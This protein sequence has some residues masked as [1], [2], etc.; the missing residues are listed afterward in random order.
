MRILIADCYTRKAFDV[1]NILRREYGKDR[2]ITACDQ[3]NRLKDIALFGRGSVCLG[4]DS[5]AIFAADLL[6]IAQS[7]QRE[8]IVFLPIEEQV[9]L[10]FYDFMK[11]HGNMNFVSMLPEMSAFLL[12]RDKLELSRFCR[13]NEIPCPRL[14]EPEDICRLVEL[15]HPLIVKPRHGSGSEGFL[16]VD[17]VEGLSSLD[18]V[19]LNEY[20]V[21]ERLA[22]GRDVKGTFFLC[23]NGQVLA[24][25]THQ[26]IRT[27]P[28]DGGVTVCSHFDVDTKAIVIGA[29]V[30]EELNWSGL[31]MVE[32]LW[33]G[34]DSR[35][36]VIEINP[37]LWG[38]ILLDQF[39]G[40]FLLKNYIE[41]SLG[42]EPIAQDIQPNAN[43]RWL[44]PFEL[45][46]LVLAKGNIPGFW[47]FGRQT[48]LINITYSSFMRALMFH[49][50]YY[51]R[52]DNYKKFLSKWL[53]S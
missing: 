43:I 11:I 10:L 18:D 49:L 34:R 46:N 15:S 6:S 23:K 47:K 25:Y 16:F 31:A 53:R 27:Y 32:L 8:E 22:N 20:V 36:K 5:S 21:Q 51:I 30:L 3:P 35:Y 39:S 42:H 48:C 50:L 7:F 41:L 12:S 13:D 52:I 9:V 38:S 24:S 1:Y 2:I 29:K 44:F 33:D 17:D 14:Y 26:R 45:I 37:R 4:T 28:I 40:A 19:Q